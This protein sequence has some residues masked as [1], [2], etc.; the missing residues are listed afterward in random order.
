MSQEKSPRLSFYD[1]KRHFD[2]SYVITIIGAA[3]S[4]EVMIRVWY[5]PPFYG[6]Y[7]LIMV[8]PA[9][10]RMLCFARNT[11]RA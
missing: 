4:M 6:S 10:L 8:R 2:G 3:I 11:K 5:E 7:D 1:R 9:I